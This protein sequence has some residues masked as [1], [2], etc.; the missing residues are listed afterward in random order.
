[1]GAEIRRTL[2]EG[3]ADGG[4]LGRHVAD[5]VRVG[6]LDHVLEVD[7]AARALEVRGEAVRAG[8]PPGVRGLHFLP[9]LVGG[10]LFLLLRRDLLLVRRSITDSRHALPLPALRIPVDR[11]RQDALLKCP[12]V[13]VS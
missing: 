8:L 1:V 9:L 13:V 3:V 11:P 10:L 5:G 4:P 2:A 12:L 6:V 7:Q